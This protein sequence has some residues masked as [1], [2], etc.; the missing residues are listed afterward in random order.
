MLKKACSLVVICL[1]SLMLS[2]CASLLG[3]ALS[4]AGAYGIYQA[5]RK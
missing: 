4:A 3:A 2:G 1:L 5:T